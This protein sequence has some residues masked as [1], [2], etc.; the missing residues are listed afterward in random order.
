MDVGAWAATNKSTA[1]TMLGWLGPHADARERLE[2]R[3]GLADDSLNS[4]GLNCKGSSTTIFSSTY[5]G[6][7]A[8]NA[9]IVIP[10]SRSSGSGFT[11]RRDD[12]DVWVRARVRVIAVR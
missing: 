10:D 5:C 2:G 3:T 4:D 6:A 11:H 7:Q 8:R 12:A 1:F 9:H